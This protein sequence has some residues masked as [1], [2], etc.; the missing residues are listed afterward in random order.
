MDTE[1][2][3]TRG[4]LWIVDRQDRF[5]S[6]LGLSRQTA[7]WPFAKLQAT[8]EQLSISAVWFRPFVVTH[9]NL[10]SIT[11]FGG[12]P[13][14]GRGLRF[15]AYFRQE[16]AVFWTF[17]RTTIIAELASLGWSVSERP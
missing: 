2:F 1:R 15:E 4:G 8:R 11:P 9:D 6:Y 16:V 5:W 3:S 14:I 17:R 12:I 10:V 7:T 13:V